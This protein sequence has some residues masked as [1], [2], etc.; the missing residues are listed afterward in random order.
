MKE[1]RPQPKYKPRVV[2]VR[3]AHQSIED[4][5]PT[6]PPSMASPAVMVETVPVLPPVILIRPSWLDLPAQQLVSRLTL[7]GACSIPAAIIIAATVHVA[8]RLL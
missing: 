3:A 1:Q 2:E 6:T 5:A 7:L 4:E 8:W